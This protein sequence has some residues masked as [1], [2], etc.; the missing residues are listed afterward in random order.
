MRVSPDDVIYCYI[1]PIIWDKIYFRSSDYSKG[2]SAYSVTSFP[3]YHT[4]PL[5][6]Y[7][8]F[9]QAELCCCRMYC[10]LV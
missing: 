8:K 6:K 4:H 7:E 10:T 5:L 9:R 2:W 3:I 1:H